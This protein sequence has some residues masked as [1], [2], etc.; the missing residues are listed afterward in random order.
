MNG[1]TDF[2]P[3]TQAERDMFDA[4]SKCIVTASNIRETLLG[5]HP[6]AVDIRMVREWGSIL[7]ARGQEISRLADTL[8]RERKMRELGVIV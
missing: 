5:R 2:M 7:R 1:S 4:A 6:G 3:A 8:E